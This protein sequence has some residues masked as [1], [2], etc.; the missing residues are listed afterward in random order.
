MNILR[1]WRISLCTFFLFGAI[2]SSAEAWSQDELSLYATPGLTQQSTP[3][4][5][6]S[7]LYISRFATCL[8]AS[9][10][11]EL[12][13]E[14]LW[15]RMG[16]EWVDSGS[17]LD[18]DQLTFGDLIDDRRGFVFESEGELKSVKYHH[19]QITVPIMV[20]YRLVQSEKWRFVAALGAS[21]DYLTTNHTVIKHGDDRERLSQNLKP[22]KDLGF[23]ARIEML[24]SRYLTERLSVEMG[25]S[26]RLGLTDLRTEEHPPLRTSNVGIR[27][28]LARRL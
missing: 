22:Y 2:L 25:P 14:L 15:L 27:V 3:D 1:I 20:H 18:V 8:G 19:Q 17:Q 9:Y 13:E 24:F 26:V 4:N 5:P 21:A 7:G 11:Y 23:S 16:F 12:I 10:R 28:G 6:H